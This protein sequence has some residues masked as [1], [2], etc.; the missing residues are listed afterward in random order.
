MTI[1]T[2]SARILMDASGVKAG[3]GLTRAEM[4]LTRQAFIDSTS[5]VERLEA[6]LRTLESARDK[7]AF[8]DEAE[9]AK[10]VAAVRAELDPTIRAERELAAARATADEQAAIQAERDLAAARAEGKALTDSLATAEERRA[11]RLTEA[12]QLLDQAAISQETYD[13]AQR[14]ISSERWIELGT[15]IRN[16]GLTT[17]AV[18]GGITAGMVVMG[19]GMLDAYAGAQ[20][21]QAGLQA[22]MRANGT[23][24]QATLGSYKA[25]GTEM[26]R[27]TKTD[28][29]AAAGLLQVAES[30][31]VS[32][33]AAE[34]AARNAIAMEAALGVDRDAAIKMT[35]ALEQ[36]N[37]TL[38][39]RYLPALRGI[40]DPADK[41]AA[42]QAALAKMFGVA[43]AESQTYA[44][45][46]AQLGNAV[47]DLQESF[48]EVLAQGLTPLMQGA[49]DMV[50]GFNELDASTKSVITYTG[51][52]VTGMAG[53]AT[54][55]GGAIAVT[56][57]LVTWYG[58]LT[59]TATGAR[60]AQISLNTAIGA[61]YVAAAAA[62]VGAGYAL[63]Q[64]LYELT[65]TAEKNAEVL[66]NLKSEMG[67][68]ATVDFAGASQESLDQYIAST[69]R[70]IEKIKQHNAE[71]GESQAWWNFWQS[72]K[73]LIQSN[74][75][76]I[77]VLNDA[78]NRA[79]KEQAATA[80]PAGPDTAAATTA[81]DKLTLSLREQIQTI[82]HTE[83][84]IQLWKLAQEGATAEQLRAVQALQQQTAA[85]QANASLRDDTNALVDS[86][87][88]QAAEMGRSEA[89]VQ[90][91]RLAA[92]GLSPEW[93]Q[94]IETLQT[95]VTAG[96]QLE[97]ANQK[98]EQMQAALQEQI[99]TAG[100]TADEVERWRL[101]QA[102]VTSEQ[103]AGVAALQQQAAAARDAA[104]AARQADEA[105]RQQ[106][107]QLATSIEQTTSRLQ[108]QIDTWGMT[109]DEATLY[110][111]A[112]QGA[113]AA[114]L[115]AVEDLQ[116]QLADLQRQK[117]SMRASDRRAT[118]VSIAASTGADLADAWQRR[119]EA[120]ASP[121]TAAES[122]AA[123]ADAAV[124]PFRRA[125]VTP[126]APDVPPI[127]AGIQPTWQPTP[128]APDL[129][130][131]PAEIQTAWADILGGPDVPAIAASIQPG[132]E[133]T[134]PAPD[135]PPIAA[136]VQPGWE[137]T[138]PAPDVP[139]IAA[140][141]QRQGI[142][143]EEA[144]RAFQAVDLGQPRKDEQLP[145]LVKI[146]KGI[147]ALVSKEGIV[148]EEVRA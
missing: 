8:R 56:G 27:L 144:A 13:R 35:A 61:G 45:A 52:A 31:G 103:L 112:A 84:E 24:T 117:E 23:L 100:M 74:T 140:T 66:G 145:W 5:D 118:D 57:Q 11:Q 40:K 129:P 76:Q 1:G 9:Y 46:S 48:G 116:D 51:L 25:F 59:A 47:G 44:G 93:L 34:R 122:A 98:L 20:D 67:G 120:A 42:A 143:A 64:S 115:A 114:E 104:E 54:A 41:A 105:K 130:P 71:L 68:I 32:G 58:T 21:A 60:I 39:S 126:A 136:T 111:L 73:D 22:A 12:K 18:A 85:A 2:L 94:L 89:E 128:A 139:P 108:E 142:T 124:D 72:N 10:A 125:S 70:Q 99:A 50:V 101:A 121:A 127:A 6:A 29:D 69:E 28:D 123:L 110:K 86:L 77:D 53:L 135:V 132:W 62:A 138:P 14:Q 82:G 79:R 119:Q 90:R 147:E 95:E 96:Q 4:K 26:Q 17:A 148:I 78:L 106:A 65:A 38:L 36:G 133:P 75:D 49:R 19:Q 131:V 88:Q 7:G 109:A 92:R 141:A 33:D 15:G 137:P 37:T 107:Q 55:A 97:A 146:A 63:G 81:V 113:S 43:E 80:T 134:P 102:G 30:Y 83:Q 3:L 91:M 16:V 87:R